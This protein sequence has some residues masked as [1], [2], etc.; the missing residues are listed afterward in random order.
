MA[1]TDCMS[2]RNEHYLKLAHN[3]RRLTADG[4]GTEMAGLAGV[5]IGLLMILLLTVKF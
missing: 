3:V 5:L 1:D 2:Q 4:D